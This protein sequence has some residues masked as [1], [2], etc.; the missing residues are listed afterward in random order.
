MLDII[1]M[2]TTFL[3]ITSGCA[4]I[5]MGNWRPFKLKYAGVALSTLSSMLMMMVYTIGSS[6][7]ECQ[8]PSAF[9]LLLGIAQISRNISFILLHLAIGRDAYFVKHYKDRRKA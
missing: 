5:A 9:F 3:T 1:I 2:F 6:V 8:I 4:A 7:K